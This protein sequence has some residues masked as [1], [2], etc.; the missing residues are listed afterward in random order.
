MRLT[1]E[2]HEISIQSLQCLLAFVFFS[3]KDLLGHL[4]LDA[5]NI[6]PLFTYIPHP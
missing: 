3:A 1:H 5:E 2:I 6:K 4:K